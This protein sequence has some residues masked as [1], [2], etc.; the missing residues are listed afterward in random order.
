MLYILGICVL[1]TFLLYIIFFKKLYQKLIFCGETLPNT[2]GFFFQLDK[3]KK[4]KP[5]YKC[6]IIEYKYL[7]NYYFQ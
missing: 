2:L 7:R 6:H 4:K 5:V 3:R 1:V